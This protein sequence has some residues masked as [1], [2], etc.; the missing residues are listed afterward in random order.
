M[1]DD[2]KKLGKLLKIFKTGADV[3]QVL[4]DGE[5]PYML[6]HLSSS[7]TN[8]LSWYEFDPAGSVLE[9]GAECGVITEFLCGRTASVTAVEADEDKCAV[10]RERTKS[11]GNVQVICGGPED[12]PSG[13]KY[14]YI[15]L[16]GAGLSGDLLSRVKGMLREGGSIFV[17]ADN[18]Y[19]LVKWAD[20][21]SAPEE[22]RA[23]SYTGFM[24]ILNDSGFPVREVYYPYPDYRLTLQMF[25]DARMPKTDEL[26]QSVPTYEGT[27]SYFF[28]EV[29]VTT[30]MV[31]EGMY[32]FFANSYLAVLTDKADVSYPSYVKYNTLRRPEL[33]LETA[34]Y[35]KDGKMTRVVKSASDPA[36]IPMIDKVE[37]NYRKLSSSY[38]GVKPVECIRSGDKIEFP[39]VDG[40]S[41]MSDVDLKTCSKEEIIDVVR[42]TIDKIFD[43][44]GGLSDFVVTP[45]F[46]EVFPGC[47]PGREEKSFPVIN[48]DSNFD[49]FIK[50]PDGI[51]CID[52]EWVADF[53]V[54]VNYVKYRTL[55]Y[56]YTKNHALIRDRI[57]LHELYEAFGLME[58]ERLYFCMEE[59]FQEYVHGEGRR[60]IF[61]DRYGLYPGEAKDKVRDETE[62]LKHTVEDKEAE[63]TSL[64]EQV[65][66]QQE[67]INDIIRAVKDPAF[68]W[69]KFRIRSERRKEEH[70]VEQ[71]REKQYK[72]VY[73][74]NTGILD[75]YKSRHG[76]YE[77][78]IDVHQVPYED[79]I[80][81]VES[82][83]TCDET[84]EYNPK[85]SVIVP[86]YNC[87]DKF[88]IPCIESVLGQTY[89]NIVLCLSDDNSPDEHVRETMRKYEN[90]PRVKCVYRK[91]NG[92][93]SLN[94][95]SAIEVA[96]GE[97]IAFLDCDDTLSPNAIYEVVKAINEAKKKGIDLDFIYSDEDKIDDEGKNRHMPHFKPDWSPDTMMSI[98]YT[99]HLGVYRKT[100]GDKTGWLREGFEGSQDYDFVLR[101]TELTTPEK[102]CH[103]PKILYHWR[104]HA[105]STALNVGSKPYFLEASRRAKV[106]ALKRRGYRGRVELVGL[107]FQWRIVYDSVM[108]PLVSIIIPSKD[109]Y[110]YL[111]RCISSLVKNTMYRNFEI[112]VVDNGSSEENKIKYSELVASAGGKYI[113]EP[114]QFNFSRMCN[115]GAEAAEGQYL[116]FLNDDIEIRDGIWLQRMVGHAELPYIGAVGAKLMYPEN[117]LIQHCGVTN[118]R[119]AGPVHSFIGKS[120]AEL[121]YFLR[122]KIEYDWIAVTA[123]CLL[124]NKEKFDGVGGFNEEFAVA[125][126]DVDLCFK[127]YEAG[128]YNVVR[129][130]AVLVHYESVSRGYDNHDDAKMER[131][132]REREKLYSMHPDLRGRDP[133]YNPNLTGRLADYTCD[134]LLTEPEDE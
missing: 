130:D 71:E 13:S 84:F 16:I 4:F 103:I 109:N 112:I 87:P 42:N 18:K 35:M 58:R 36:S 23:L 107:T 39:F 116:L 59:R 57:E 37:E 124:V 113:Y 106:E 73:A 49:N 120:D 53:P 126:N 61:T 85:I 97:F 90:D 25:S 5:D 32:P 62:S 28:D 96:D 69:K 50:T 9:I 80:E 40:V 70:R 102:I 128:Y 91:E 115:K 74:L 104:E 75:F 81:Y 51:V 44:N 43:Y 3:E 82:H 66:A 14:D 133:F 131:L 48:I 119:E 65:A 88:L 98:M 22:E 8:L 86:V 83:Y 100:L 117:G 15:T 2:K 67:L 105:G 21:S 64:K 12:V 79:W 101:L 47:C 114:M 68:A 41:L 78:V 121:M 60:Y 30:D 132:I 108:L 123:A 134:N 125:F 95:N 99:C 93:I 55:Q 38:A 33:R 24:K 19:G 20:P 31:Q 45:G 54:P 52:Y 26:M 46:T 77:P 27:G 72:A 122:N 89:T 1:K 76:E 118:L 94:S 29:K 7:R 111:N 34:L 6:Y 63:I 17:A 110:D 129:E 10:I 11:R 92:H 56:F 127:L